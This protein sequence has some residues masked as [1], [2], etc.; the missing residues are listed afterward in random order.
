MTEY[1]VIY[2]GKT[3]AIVELKDEDVDRYLKA[4]IKGLPKA[5]IL[6]LGPPKKQRTKKKMPK[7]EKPTID[8]TADAIVNQT[9][10]KVL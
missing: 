1:K 10:T 3:I 7:K 5:S 6:A 8:E 2:K 4:L 9:I